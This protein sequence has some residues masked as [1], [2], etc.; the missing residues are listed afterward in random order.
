[1]GLPTPTYLVLDDDPRLHPGRAARVRAGDQLSGRVG[2][3]HPQ[4]L[5]ALELK[6]PDVVVAELAI[7]GLSGGQPSV[8]RSATPSRHPV[9]DRDLAVVVEEGTA[10]AETAGAIRRHGG[11][12]LRSV[13][14][15]DI[16]RG[17]PLGEH[18]KSLAFRLAFQAEDR[19]L[20]ESEID[21]AVAAITG[22]LATDVGGRL[23]T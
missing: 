15:F 20:T 11:A 6:A 2:S 9:V 12:L 14:L 1:M 23:R 22:G 4:V 19:T 5:E 3:T 16:Y 18:E 7:A 17:R 21:D 8:P 13:T 10:A